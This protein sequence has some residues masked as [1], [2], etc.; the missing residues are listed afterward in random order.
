MLC[1]NTNKDLN[2]ERDLACE[3]RQLKSFGTTVLF[4]LHSNLTRE[5]Y[6]FKRIHATTGLLQNFIEQI[7]KLQ[8]VSLVFSSL[9]ISQS[10][11][12]LVRQ[13][14]FLMAACHL[15]STDL[16]NQHTIVGCIV[17]ETTLKIP[18]TR[19]SNGVTYCF[20]CW[21]YHRM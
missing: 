14:Y 3:S 16:K 17:R 2:K 6:F 15:L 11:S 19:M 21:T 8:N 4:F 10:I 13:R 12:I 1:L 18:R 20:D 5:H 9:S 7:A